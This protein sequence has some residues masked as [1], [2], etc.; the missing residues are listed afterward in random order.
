MHIRI[1]SVALAV[2]IILVA[3]HGT[4]LLGCVR[5]TKLAA[6]P[7]LHCPMTPVIVGAEAPCCAL[8]SPQPASTTSASVPP[9]TLLAASFE[10]GE[11]QER[12][13]QSHPISA[14]ALSAS[15]PGHSQAWLG[16]FLI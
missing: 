14:A 7:A 8:Q 9:V 6:C 13:A 16:S 11:M 12:V 1:K 3:A 4:P 5:S 2:A 15:P 10:N